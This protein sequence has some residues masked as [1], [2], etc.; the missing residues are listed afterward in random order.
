MIRA[1]DG[2]ILFLIKALVALPFLSK[3]SLGSFGVPVPFSLP[4]LIYQQGMHPFVNVFLCLLLGVPLGILGM[5]VR[6]RHHLSGFYK[7]FVFVLMLT[8]TVQ[9]LLQISF[10]NTEDSS[11]VQMGALAVSLFMIVIYGLI[12]PSLWE[13]REFLY[14]VQRW[15]GALVLLSLLLWVTS[16]GAVFKGGRF[17]GVFKHIPHMVTCATVAF[18]FSLVTLLEDKRVKHKVWTVLILAASFSAIILTGTRSSAAAALM[19]FVVTMVLHKTATNQGRILKFSSLTLLLSF[20]LFFG[21]HVYEFARGVATGQG[22]LGAREAQDGVASRWEEVERGSQIFQQEPWLGYGLLSKFSSGREV[23]VSSYNA[24]KDPHNILI[25]AG[26]IGGWPLLVLAAISLILM[27]VGSLK[28]LL[29]F[30]IYKRQVAIYL[31]SHIPI[32]TIYH[33]HLSLGGMADR[34]YWLVFGFIA[35]SVSRTGK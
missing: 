33:V 7:I 18:I 35:A 2:R 15:A 13:V 17:V 19:A 3:I 34:L 29:T 20:A 30:D 6:A 21:G 28:A 4:P 11:V 23:D 1:H 5:K 25:S 32:L 31:L 16:G 24:M 27:A 22:A 10:V 14:F 8:M 12:I 26:V 9:T